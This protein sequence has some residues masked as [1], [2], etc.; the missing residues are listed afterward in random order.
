MKDKQE[1][2]RDGLDSQESHTP[3]MGRSLVS[4]KLPLQKNAHNIP[5]LSPNSLSK[6]GGYQASATTLIGMDT[7]SSLGYEPDT[8]TRIKLFVHLAGPPISRQAPA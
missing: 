6:R 7:R 3:E 4:G 2:E 1:K 8:R 5:R